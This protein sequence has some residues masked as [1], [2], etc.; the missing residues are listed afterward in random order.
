MTGRIHFV[1]SADGTRIALE[2]SGRGP[3]LLIVHGTGTIRATWA[4]LFAAHFTTVAM[5]RRGRG[6]SGD[7]PQYDIERETEDVLAA[8]ESLDTPVVLFGHSFGGLCALEAAAAGADVAA[9]ILYEP[10]IH[11]EVATR[12]IERLEAFIATGDAEAAVRAHYAAAGMSNAEIEAIAASP[13]WQARVAAAATIPRELRAISAHQFSGDRA[14]DVDMPALLL[15]GGE[16]PA[17]VANAVA[18]LGKALPNARTVVMPGQAHVAMYTAPEMLA[19]SV[20]S[21]WRDVAAAQS[22][23]APRPPASSPA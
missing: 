14:A 4:P 7:S 13:G 18:T 16:S 12:E 20:F 8:I 15:L 6:D 21:F 23:A 2:T 19:D 5:E 11:E 1:L 10:A 9:L 22:G 17:P 3:N